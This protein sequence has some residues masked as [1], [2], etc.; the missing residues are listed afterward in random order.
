MSP[1]PTSDEIEAA[2]AE[3]R[4][5]KFDEAVEI[6]RTVLGELGIKR[7]IF[8][9]DKLEFDEAT[10]LEQVATALET[11]QISVQDVLDD[12]PTLA[13]EDFDDAMDPELLRGAFE[14][15]WASLDSS[16]RKDGFERFQRRT[17]VASNEPSRVASIIALFEATSEVT[18]DALTP[19]EWEGRQKELV[20][21][22][23]SGTATLFLFDKDLG[24]GPTRRDE[25]EAFVQ[26]LAAE[27]PGCVF[28]LVSHTFTVD[29]EHQDTVKLVKDMPPESRVLAVAKAHLDESPELFARRIRAVA[30]FD[31]ISSFVD[32]VCEAFGNALAATRD[33]LLQLTPTTLERVLV[34]A[35]PRL[36]VAE[37]DVIARLLMSD[38]RYRVEQNTRLDQELHALTQRLHNAMSAAGGDSDDEP[39]KTG[40]QTFNRR[41]SFIDQDYLNALMM[42][43]GSGD[44]FRL[45]PLPFKR[46]SWSWTAASVEDS[47]FIVTEQDCDL[48]LRENG[49]RSREMAI[50]RL[51][52]LGVGKGDAA[53]PIT[54]PR[55]CPTTFAT[56]H[57]DH[58]DVFVVPTTALDLAAVHPH[59]LA[60]GA[61]DEEP[62]ASLSAYWRLRYLSLRDGCRQ[63]RSRHEAL[64]KQKASQAMKE[65]SLRG[66][67]PPMSAPFVVRIYARGLGFN[68]QRVARLR[69]PRSL[70]VLQRLA[71]QLQRIGYDE[72]IA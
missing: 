57:V 26:S 36:N 52:R 71:Q 60:S 21:A 9:D 56:W 68:L 55:F 10:A 42:P 6:V 46:A 67:L 43:L 58:R 33:E 17:D 13:N 61:L 2:R 50:T 15:R 47:Y 69:H 59:G 28:V 51:L 44:V 5:R 20:A 34:N 64:T 8:V 16:Y 22:S 41:E 4:Q 12:F 7:V 66:L 49:A 11:E 3:K 14:D 24:S 54:L 53:S 18:V 40:L 30:L 19:H 38:L 27:I 1:A 62:P 70:E 23:A 72:E 35:P 29:S 25:G 48:E 45:V 65:A 31:T 39:S 37:P 63:L 32:R